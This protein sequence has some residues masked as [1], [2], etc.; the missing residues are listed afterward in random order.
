VTGEMYLAIRS[1]EQFVKELLFSLLLASVVIFFVLTM[2]FRSIR[3]GLV[4]IVPNMAPLIV[5]MGYLGLRGYDLNPGNV[6]VFAIGLG[7]AVDDTIHFLARFQDELSSGR[8]LKQAIT[9]TARGSGKAILLTSVL[10]I[11]GMLILLN[12]SFV[13]TRRFAELTIVTMSAALAGDLILLPAMIRLVYGKVTVKSEVR[14]P[15]SPR[16]IV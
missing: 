13:P 11:G 2:F 12:S 3:L 8:D 7:I 9:N 5:T 6:M 4:S 1:M 10:I 16:V 14:S 15:V